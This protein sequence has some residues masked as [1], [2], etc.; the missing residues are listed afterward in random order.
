P[1]EQENASTRWRVDP[2]FV[3]PSYVLGDLAT[4]PL[5]LVETM[6][7][8]RLTMPEQVGGFRLRDLGELQIY[9]GHDMQALPVPAQYYG[10]GA[11]QGLADR[12]HEADKTQLAR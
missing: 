5:F 10:A 4:H 12:A 1:V 2:R 3:G 9:P 7:P 11:F 6:P 8:Y